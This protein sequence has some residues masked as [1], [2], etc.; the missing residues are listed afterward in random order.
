MFFYEDN[1]VA[2]LEDLLELTIGLQLRILLVIIEGIAPEGVLLVQGVKVVAPATTVL[3]VRDELA[4]L[5]KLE[6]V[7]QTEGGSSVCW[8]HDMIEGG[9]LVHTQVTI[10]IL[11]MDGFH[12]DSI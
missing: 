3:L 1:G 2:F 11:T 4:I 6:R 9:H 8:G 12:Q 7:I 10:T 5:I